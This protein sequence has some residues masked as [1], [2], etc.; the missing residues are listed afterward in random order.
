MTTFRDVPRKQMEDQPFRNSHLAPSYA[1]DSI[2]KH[3]IN[4]ITPASWFEILFVTSYT[5]LIGGRSG[6][7]SQDST[8]T[9]KCLILTSTPTNTDIYT[10]KPCHLLVVPY[11][12]FVMM[13][14]YTISVKKECS[15]SP[16][17]IVETC[18]HCL[19]NV[20]R[21]GTQVEVYY[22]INGTL[23]CGQY[24]KRILMW[25]NQSMVLDVIGYQGFW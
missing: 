12:L 10:N 22:K 16:T 2:Q 13:V 15:T 1:F 11:F 4:N 18:G 9:V 3:L 5:R 7:L 21:K 17:S 14:F 8:V 23:R 25:T 19:L 24:L 20:D 6:R